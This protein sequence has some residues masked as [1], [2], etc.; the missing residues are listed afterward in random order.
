MP[1]CTT[2]ED[3]HT[4]IYE[5]FHTEEVSDAKIRLLRSFSAC[6]LRPRTMV[7]DLNGVCTSKVIMS[8]DSF[9]NVKI[10]YDKKENFG[11]MT[12]TE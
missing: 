12:Y 6:D 3:E 4:E 10:T 1:H 9:L 2:F 7:S 11:Y 8:Q 5:T